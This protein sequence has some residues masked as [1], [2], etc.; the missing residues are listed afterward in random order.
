MRIL[1][2]WISTSWPERSLELQVST[3]I[4]I[5]Q[6]VFVSIYLCFLV[7]GDIHGYF[8]IHYEDISTIESENECL[9]NIKQFIKER[10]DLC[11]SMDILSFKDISKSKK[12]ASELWLAILYDKIPLYLEKMENRMVEINVL[13]YLLNEQMRI[14]AARKQIYVKSAGGVADLDTNTATA[15]ANSSQHDIPDLITVSPASSDA[16]LF[17][18]LEHKSNY[19]EHKN[20]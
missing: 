16:T 11:D 3:E 2:F 6:G 10:A 14:L 19:M 17:D 12:S 15:A 4:R 18:E 13:L 20:D 9:E 7:Q 5:C 1:Q 8:D